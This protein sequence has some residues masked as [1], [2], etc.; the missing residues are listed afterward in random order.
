MHCFPCAHPI[1]WRGPH[2]ITNKVD[3]FVTYCVH[4]AFAMCALAYSAASHAQ[5]GAAC[6][7]AKQTTPSI[8]ACAIQQFQNID[9]SQSILYAD[10]MQALSAH[11]RPALRKAQTQWMRQ[12]ASQ[13]KSQHAHQESHPLWPRY[14]HDCLAKTTETRRAA[15][16][17]W[18]H[19]GQAPEQ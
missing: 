5:A 12:R 8:N 19:H 3:Y 11:E 16:L 7:P 17:H 2:A 14:Y 1:V 6:D 13:C 10:V 9:T 15:L 4:T 18:L